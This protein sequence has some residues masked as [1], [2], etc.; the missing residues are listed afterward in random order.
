ML[1][2]EETT[3]RGHHYRVKNANMRPAPVQ[4]PRPP[5]TLAAW[6]PKTLRVAAEYADSWNFAPVQPNLTPEQNLHETARRNRMLDDYCLELG[7]DPAAITRSLLVFPRASDDPFDSD[8]AFHDFVGSYR[9][10]GI[11]EFIIYWWRE[12]AL[13][14]G[15]DRSIVERCA[16]REMIEHL[17]TETIPALRAGY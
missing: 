13:E 2:N 8:D 6:G 5:L 12:D 7:R 17:A 1:R 4:Q 11:D 16:D 14:Y 9:E 3:Y 10:I 15:Y